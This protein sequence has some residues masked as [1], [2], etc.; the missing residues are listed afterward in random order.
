M[1][2]SEGHNLESI[3]TEPI[4]ELKV[5]KANKIRLSQTS[6]VN[7]FSKRTEGKKTES[8]NKENERFFLVFF[9]LMESS[10]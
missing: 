7:N 2:S 3:S 9:Q 1:K 5:D 4:N 10:Y 6:N 8:K